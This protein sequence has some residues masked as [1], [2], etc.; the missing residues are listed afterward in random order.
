[1]KFLLV[2]G[3]VLASFSLYPCPITISNDDDQTILIVDPKGVEAILLSPNQTGMIDPT[4]THPLMRFLSDETLDIYYAKNEKPYK[5][6]KRYRLTEK[7]CTDNEDENQLT[8]KQ[9]LQFEKNPTDRFI[10]KRFQITEK[11]HVHDH[12]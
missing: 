4:L 10:L 12:H 5:F 6:Y 8:I 11:K 2:L 7:Y 1:M 9:I 3:T